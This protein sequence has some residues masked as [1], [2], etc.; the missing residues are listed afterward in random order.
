M[1]QFKKD[2]KYNSNGQQA[3][4]HLPNPDELYM[5]NPA[6][7]QNFSQM[8]SQAS[9]SGRST[10]GSL[11]EYSN[12]PTNYQG[13]KPYQEL[14]TNHQVNHNTL[15][16]PMVSLSPVVLD[17]NN[18]SQFKE[19]LQLHV[20]TIGILVAEKAELQ[21]KLQQQLKKSDKKQDEC[22]ELMGRLKA[23]RQKIADLEKLVQQLSTNN[24]QMQQ[25]GHEF[26]KNSE[27]ENLRMEINSN[28]L[29]IDELKM[30]LNE[31]N[32]KL[33]IK[34]QETQK[35]AQLTLDLKSQLEILQLKVIQQTSATGKEDES[36]KET[37][38]KSTDDEV[39]RRLKEENSN[40]TSQLSEMNA[41][42]D[43]N[44]QKLKV[45]YENYVQQ[46][47][48]QIESLV[49]QINRM[50]DEREHYFEKID[51][52]ELK[53]KN[54]TELNRKLQADYDDLKA[55]NQQQQQV[56]PSTPS[57]TPTSRDEKI[58]L[59][60]NEIK[61][62]KHQ[63]EMLVKEEKEL[64]KLVQE[65]DNSLNNLNKLIENYE[66]EREQYSNLL[67]QSHNDKQTISRILKQNNDLKQQ[68]TELQ[69]AYVN[70]T[71]Q[72]LDL[73]TKLDSQQ[74]KLKQFEMNQV[75]VQQSSENKQVDQNQD[76]DDTT[77]GEW[78]GEEQTENNNE[79]E[80][81]TL[82][83]SIRVSSLLFTRLPL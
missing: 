5:L 52:L 64:N 53:L 8:P 57:Q 16:P 20:Q 61:Y 42:F 35:L 54:S 77:G 24:Q 71:Q 79:F 21:S 80:N 68:L 12:L 36:A 14:K 18:L 51:S 29:F 62:F 58:D 13:Q 73:A 11:L 55:H 48:R 66:K 67:E 4:T 82:M 44:K 70:V 37:R 47:Q 3:Q 33:Q 75:L 30:R 7:H 1:K 72:N 78:D 9:L 50:S 28:H 27:L 39:V 40:L 46:L 34:Q 38:D 6:N 41:K 17:A 45:E 76:D 15:S 25:N 81:S 56:E 10:P 60:E 26:G 65:R 23:S 43:E 32:E 63:I 83:D 2:A 31:S 59:L 19:Q 22:D 69:D 74:F 49:D